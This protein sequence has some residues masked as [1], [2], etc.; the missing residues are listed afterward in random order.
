MGNR[1]LPSGRRCNNARKFTSKQTPVSHTSCDNQSARHEHRRF[2]SVRQL[3]PLLCR[4]VRRPF[5]RPSC[6]Q[7]IRHK[8]LSSVVAS[9]VHTS[10][11]RVR[12]SFL[13]VR[14]RSSIR[15][16]YPSIQQSSLIQDDLYTFLRHLIDRS[17]WAFTWSVHISSV[18]SSICKPVTSFTSH[19]SIRPLVHTLFDRWPHILIYIYIYIYMY[20]IY[21]L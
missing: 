2:V 10:S 13:V 11:V 5:I 19:S 17:S 7:F 4:N 3:Y 8:L 1:L 14:R 9:S 16:S 20:Y 21:I 18:T 6:C 15:R 12:Q